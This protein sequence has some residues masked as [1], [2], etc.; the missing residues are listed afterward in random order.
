MPYRLLRT[1]GE[2]A[3]FLVQDVIFELAAVPSRTEER[4]VISVAVAARGSEGCRRFP[5]RAPAPGHSTQCFWTVSARSATL[6][7]ALV[8]HW[9]VETGFP[10]PSGSSGEKVASAPCQSSTCG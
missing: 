8:T 3:S 9:V 10:L 6:L 2:D 1:A 4:S 7:L 5:S